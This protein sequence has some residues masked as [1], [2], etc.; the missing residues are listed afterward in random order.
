M[1]NGPLSKIE[2]FY[3]EQN[4]DS[5]TPEDL[6]IELDRS[7]KQVRK[8]LVE[9]GKKVPLPATTAVR[10]PIDDLMIKKERNG[11]IVATVMSQAASEYSDS[12][13]PKIKSQKMGNV[14]HNPKGKK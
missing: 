7:V 9:F 5:K 12:Q 14:M 6:A 2:K 4:P 1:K 10:K 3:I 11:Q 13:R 8:H